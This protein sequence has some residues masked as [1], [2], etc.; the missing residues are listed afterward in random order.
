MAT[1][2]VYQPNKGAAHNPRGNGK[3]ESDLIEIGAF[4]KKEA[5][6]SGKPYYSGAFSKDAAQ[7][8]DI[9]GK[10]ASSTDGYTLLMFPNKAE[11]PNAPQIRV[12]VGPK[13]DAK[14][15]KK[16]P[17]KAAFKAVAPPEDDSNDLF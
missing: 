17:Q 6:E 10:L 3:T 14:S 7:L 2:Q 12:Y 8:A 11:N 16:A 1:N 15:F 4:W 9:F 13:R 5:K